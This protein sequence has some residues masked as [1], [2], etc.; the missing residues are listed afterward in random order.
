MIVQRMN[1]RR[2]QQVT[3]DREDDRNPFRADH[4]GK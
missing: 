4:K 1:G 2:R 3:D